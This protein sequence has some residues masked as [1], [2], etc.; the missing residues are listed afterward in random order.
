MY[1]YLSKIENFEKNL[2]YLILLLCTSNFYEYTMYEN[3]EEKEYFIMHLF[4]TIC[5]E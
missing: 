2:K 5:I 4:K 1:R 3:D